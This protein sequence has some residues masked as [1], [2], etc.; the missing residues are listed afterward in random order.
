MWGRQNTWGAG[1]RETR[2]LFPPAVMT[3]KIWMEG[4]FLCFWNVHFDM[5]FEHS[6][7]HQWLY[8]VA[9]IQIL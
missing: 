3:N 2:S 6:F 7:D 8:L 9:Q 1:Q 4:N 5:F